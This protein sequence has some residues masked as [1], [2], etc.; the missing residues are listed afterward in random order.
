[1]NDMCEQSYRAS[2]VKFRN[3]NDVRDYVISSTNTNDAIRSMQLMF[4][5]L[6]MQ[7]GEFDLDV[8]RKFQTIHHIT[9]NRAF[10]SKETKIKPRELKNKNLLALLKIVRWLVKTYIELDNKL[11]CYLLKESVNKN[12]FAIQNIHCS[13]DNYITDVVCQKDWDV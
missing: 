2:L 9:W 6:G 11:G 13:Q 4:E 8:L 5:K 7:P 1:M 12:N 3:T 10:N